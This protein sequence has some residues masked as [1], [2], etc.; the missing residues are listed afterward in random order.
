LPLQQVTQIVFSKGGR[1]V[2]AGFARISN[3]KAITELSYQKDC[4][5]FCLWNKVI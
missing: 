3:L 2:L 5:Q 1:K 4:F